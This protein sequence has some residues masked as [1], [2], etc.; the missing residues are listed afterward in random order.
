MA[1]H[2]LDVRADQIVQWLKDERAAGRPVG[3]RTMREYVTEPL[4]DREEAGLS[5][6]T[7]ASSLMTVGILEAWPVGEEDGWRLQVRVE[8]A[9]GPH[10]PEDESVSDRTEEID[11]D[12]FE[13]EFIAPDRG[14]VF[15]SVTTDTP[16]AKR[17]F[18]RLFANLLR[19]RHAG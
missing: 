7:D 8:D 3:I 1:T 2:E 19:D 6:E 11:L 14:T 15:T 18:D 9:L 4:P 5:E 12:D 10:T 16:S 17:R 13:A